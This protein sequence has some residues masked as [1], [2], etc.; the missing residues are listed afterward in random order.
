MMKAVSVKEKPSCMLETL[1]G[2]VVAR[3]HAFFVVYSTDGAT[4]LCT[5]RGKLRRARTLNRRPP[6]GK[7]NNHPPTG[8]L[9]SETDAALAIVAVGDTVRIVPDGPAAGV[10]EAILPRRNKLSRAAIESREEQILLANLD[11]VVLVFAV[12]DPLPRLGLLDRYLVLAED[13]GIEAAICFNKIDLGAPEEV[14]EAMALYGSLGYPILQTSVVQNSGIEELRERIKDR[15]TLL[16]GPSGVGKSSLLN[17]IEPGA[18]QRVGEVNHVTGAGRHTT[19]GV[20]LFHLTMGGWLADSAGI[21]ELKPWNIPR[22][23]LPWAF[24]EFRP[25]I[26]QCEFADCTHQEDEEG[27]AILAA[28]ENGTIAPSR[29]ITYLRLFAGDEDA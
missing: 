9:P 12:Q 23:R 13:G 4:R 18:A 22:D 29:Y 10:I 20:Q 21:R 8:L 14:V 15:T 11:L 24:V 16:T 19:T 1:E 6:S 2:L 5:L 7:P 17:A 25:L 26:G 28:V 27:C 3:A